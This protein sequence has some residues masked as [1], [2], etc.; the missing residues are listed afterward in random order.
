MKSPSEAIAPGDRGNVDR[1]LRRL[2]QDIGEIYRW[3]Q[4]DWDTPELVSWRQGVLGGL[5]AV[6]TL[7]EDDDD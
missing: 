6:R 4:Q 3:H 1:H 2:S 7:L 5:D